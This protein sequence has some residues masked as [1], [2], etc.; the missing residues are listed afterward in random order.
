MYAVWMRT[1][2]QRFITLLLSVYMCV[3]V[4]WNLFLK[5]LVANLLGRMRL[6]HWDFLPV[7]FCCTPSLVHIH[8][9]LGQ[10]PLAF[11]HG[12]CSYWSHWGFCLSKDCRVWLQSWAD[13]GW[14]WGADAPKHLCKRQLQLFRFTL[15]TL[16]QRI[17]LSDMGRPNGIACVSKDYL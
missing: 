5:L 7:H 15:A 8:S 6:S 17:D 2:G 11:M 1:Y 3:L 16:M 4:I 13:P 12:K 9:M 10:I 14:K